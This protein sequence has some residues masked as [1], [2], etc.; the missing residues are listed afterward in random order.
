V[1][2]TAGGG[3][4]G[5]ATTTGKGSG[6][7]IET[8]IR[9]PACADKLATPS[10]A[11]ARRI[12]VFMRLFQLSF[13]VYVYFLFQG[14][15]ASAAQPFTHHYGRAGVILQGKWKNNKPLR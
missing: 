6:N 1:V 8:P 7:P 13:I 3:Q 10:I 5:A 14:P 15:A 12:L 11:T 2:T 4:A 9:T